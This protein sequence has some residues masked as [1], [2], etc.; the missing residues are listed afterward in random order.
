MINVTDSFAV[1][2]T[3]HKP[4]PSGISCG[5]HF[6]CPVAAPHDKR[7]P[8][9]TPLLRAILSSFCPFLVFLDSESFSQNTYTPHRA[10]A[11]QYR[12]VAMGTASDQPLPVS[13][14]TAKASSYGQEKAAVPFFDSD[15]HTA[16]S[17]P[18]ISLLL[19][20]L[21]HTSIAGPS[22]WTLWLT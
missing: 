18:Q 15:A 16:L 21:K 8:R 19:P 1:H 5:C 22:V 12:G 7:K 13:S 6:G 10:G 3:Q 14:P 17:G 11:T 9:Y 2:G 4:Y 20:Q